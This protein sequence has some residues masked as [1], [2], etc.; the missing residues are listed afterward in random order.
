MKCAACGYF[1]GYNVE[2]DCID[3]DSEFIGTEK[4]IYIEKDGNWSSYTERLEIIVCPK[5]GT[6]KVEV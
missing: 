1:R 5:C 6:L 4:H 2:N 3:G